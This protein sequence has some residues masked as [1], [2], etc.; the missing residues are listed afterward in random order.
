MPD[1]NRKLEELA[2]QLHLW[3][4]EATKELNPESYNPNAQKAYEDMTEEQK[5]ID[6]YIADK[7]LELINQEKVNELNRL[8]ISFSKW[9]LYNY[10]AI[11]KELENRIAELKS[12]RD[13]NE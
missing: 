3:Y 5:F 13:G 1:L 2:K 10:L 9:E 4:L 7:C 11:S 8:N 12:R 6:R